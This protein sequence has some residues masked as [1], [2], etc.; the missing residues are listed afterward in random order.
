MI[1]FIIKETRKENIIV[2]EG[3]LNSIEE[4][5]L[6]QA[7]MENIDKKFPGIEIANLHSN[8]I[9]NLSFKEKAKRFI[10]NKLY[11]KKRGLTIIGPAKLVKQ[12]KRDPNNVIL[13]MM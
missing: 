5:N 12:I 10:V 8:N 13:K 3:S 1:D 11:G 9:E 7:T 4:A 2:I 6:I